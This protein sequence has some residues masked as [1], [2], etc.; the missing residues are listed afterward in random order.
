M[1][2]AFYIDSFSS[3]HFHEMFNASSLQMFSYL[4]YI[5]DYFVQKESFENVKG[6]LGKLPQNVHIHIHF[7]LKD[8]KSQMRNVFRKIWAA[9][10]N[11]F[12]IIKAPRDTD[13]IINYNTVISLYPI[14]FLVKLLKKRVLIIC[15]GEMQDIL[16]LRHNSF[17]FKQSIKFFNRKSVNVAENL[18]F[19]V[20]GES[21]KRNILQI[22][23]EQVGKKLLSFDHTA[24]FSI[25]TALNS[26]KEKDKLVLG[27]VGGYRLNKGA[28][29]FVKMADLFRDDGNIE[30]RF[31]GNV[32][33]HREEL[34]LAG[35]KIPLGV[36]D[37]FLTRD[38]MYEHIRKLDYVLCCFPSDGY[39]YTASGSA[40]D[41][42]DCEVPILALRND[43]FVGLFELCGDF[44]FLED[45]FDG[46]KRRIVWLKEHKNDLKWNVGKVKEMLSPA[47]AAQRF[48]E[49]RWFK[50]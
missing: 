30:F 9:V 32:R 40:F 2:K 37:A 29:V 25:K 49:S 14:N 20:L 26:H 46:L 50:S 19:A 48:S 38:E 45:D 16:G 4:Y 42:I 13:V 21:I 44:G 47:S 35:V 10:L 1:R 39:K 11:V 23:S 6:I 7:I 3:E 33:G 8:K 31:I 12:Y 36:G 5:I 15:H 34:V 27:Y 22:V 17:L 24:V 41:G 28:D 18:W 43:Y